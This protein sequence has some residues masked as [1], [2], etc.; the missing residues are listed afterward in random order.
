MSLEQ[1]NIFRVS[2]ISDMTGSAAKELSGRHGWRGPEC[3][4][5]WERLDEMLRRNGL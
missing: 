1:D 5:D 2:R 4:D 3:R